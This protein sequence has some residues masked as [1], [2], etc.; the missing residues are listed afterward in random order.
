LFSKK[1]HVPR[2]RGFIAKVQ[3]MDEILDICAIKKIFKK[4]LLTTTELCDNNPVFPFGTR[5][6]LLFNDTKKPALSFGR[7]KAGKSYHA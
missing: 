6:L 7:A 5:F 3:T 1:S 2:K 4:E